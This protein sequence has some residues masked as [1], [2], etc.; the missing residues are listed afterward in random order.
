M[1][2][3]LIPRD[4]LGVA[5]QTEGVA[6]IVGVSDELAVIPK[7]ELARSLEM[8]SYHA[9]TAVVALGIC[10]VGTASSFLLP[11]AAPVAVAMA[12]AGTV[13]TGYC[14]IALVRSLRAKAIIQRQLRAQDLP[15]ARLLKA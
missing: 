7:Q 2:N 1:N 3:T 10:I 15:R 9:N 13:L 8:E 4:E 14:G 5:K 6:L 12:I 11:I